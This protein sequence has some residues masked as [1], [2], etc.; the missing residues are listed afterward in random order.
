MSGIYL[1]TF[2]I[3]NQQ[4]NVRTYA[5]QYVGPVWIAFE[6]AM[7]LGKINPFSSWRLQGKRFYLEISIWM[8]FPKNSGVFPPNHPWINKVFHEN[9]PSILAETPLFLETPI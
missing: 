2:T 6:E 1:P 5:M 8:L 9:S 7:S 3:K 4:L